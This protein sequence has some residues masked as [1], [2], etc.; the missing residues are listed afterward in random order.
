MDRYAAGYAAGV[1]QGH[2]DTVELVWEFI[3][4]HCPPISSKG[5]T[6]VSVDALFAV[7][8]PRR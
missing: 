3:R 4:D 5:E 8:E 6:P 1:R 2:A 7:I